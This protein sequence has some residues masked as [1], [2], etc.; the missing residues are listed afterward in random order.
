[1]IDDPIDFANSLRTLGL[2]TVQTSGMDEE[3]YGA[4][5]TLIHYQNMTP[6]GRLAWAQANAAEIRGGW[7]SN[8]RLR[9]R[10]GALFSTLNRL[11]LGTFGTAFDD[12]SVSHQATLLSNPWSLTDPQFQYCMLYIKTG[13][14]P[15]EDKFVDKVFSKNGQ[16]VVQHVED[17]AKKQAMKYLEKAAIVVGGKTV[18]VLFKVKKITVV[19]LA[20]DI[21]LD[22]LKDRLKEMDK[23]TT[24]P[25]YLLD[26]A[27]RIHLASKGKSTYKS[28][29][30]RGAAFSS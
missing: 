27:R 7:D 6:T 21:G 22:M 25:R 12:H 30:F 16:I 18:E 4:A 13:Q 3:A 10:R 28:D 14:L 11:R 9:S 2:S 5:L 26:E 17:E 15:D 1:M 24:I 20:I 29:A 8:S 19:G 23:Q